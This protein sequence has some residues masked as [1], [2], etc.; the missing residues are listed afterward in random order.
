MS[1]ICEGDEEEESD[2]PDNVDELAMPAP[3]A[4]VLE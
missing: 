4:S 2:N 1:K 3:S